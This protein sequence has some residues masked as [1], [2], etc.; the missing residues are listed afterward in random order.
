[1]SDSISSLL[2]STYGSA[3]MATIIAGGLNDVLGS[4]R[5]YSK[6]ETYLTFKAPNRNYSK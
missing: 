2:A 3:M 5:I 4:N 6:S 1:M